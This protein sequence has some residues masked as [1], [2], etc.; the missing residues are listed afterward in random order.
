MQ[1]TNAVAYEKYRYKD[2]NVPS[3]KK[4]IDRNDKTE[5]WPKSIVGSLNWLTFIDIMQ[6]TADKID[7]DKYILPSL[8]KKIIV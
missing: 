8:L 6:S 4:K 1:N 7:N 2:E 5:Y 3:I